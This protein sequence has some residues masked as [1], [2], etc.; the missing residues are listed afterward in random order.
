MCLIASSCIAASIT[1]EAFY[2]VLEI[3]NSMV[4]CFRPS[5]SIPSILL[6][7]RACN[8]PATFTQS[9]LFLMRLLL[10]CCALFL[11][12]LCFTIS[13]TSAQTSATGIPYFQQHVHYSLSAT[14]EDDKESPAID[15]TGSLEYS[16]NSPD[17]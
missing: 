6:A 17:T 5:F 10:C 13:E 9:S 8:L 15:G 14:F 3:I 7:D 11:V 12:A 2:P 16:N 4:A 1:T